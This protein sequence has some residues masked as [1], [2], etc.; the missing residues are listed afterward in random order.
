VGVFVPSP[1]KPCSGKITDH[2]RFWIAEDLPKHIPLNIYALMSKYGTFAGTGLRTI[3]GIELAL[4]P[5]GMNDRTGI[6]GCAVFHL[7]ATTIIISPV[8]NP[9]HQKVRK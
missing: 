5:L 4:T 8:Q 1:Q 2:H 3:A 6:S 9:D 7:K